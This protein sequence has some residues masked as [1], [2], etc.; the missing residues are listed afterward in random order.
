MSYKGE[1]KTGKMH[2]KGEYV[3]AN[4]YEFKGE[5]ADDVIE[6]YG[7]CLWKTRKAYTGQW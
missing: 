1:Y 7:T 2:G 4:M 3:I 6:G 5:F